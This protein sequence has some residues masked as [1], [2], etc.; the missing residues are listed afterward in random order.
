MSGSNHKS[1]KS[2]NIYYIHINKDSLSESSFFIQK[3]TN[4]NCYEKNTNKNEQQN[5]T[6]L[7][8]NNL[9]D[10]LLKNKQIQLIQKCPHYTESIRLNKIPKTVQEKEIDSVM[11]SCRSGNLFRSDHIQDKLFPIK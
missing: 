6:M 2:L 1:I 7:S 8:I 9:G 5:I 11:C 10:K 3:T 4:R